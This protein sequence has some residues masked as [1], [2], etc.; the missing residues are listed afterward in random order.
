MDT[1]R[2]VNTTG[3]RIEPFYFGAA[4]TPLFGLLHTPAAASGR[5][6]CVVI[7][8]PAGHEY[9]QSHR[10]LRVLAER[11]S[12]TGFPALRF[13][14]Y[15]C[16]DSSGDRDEGTVDRWRED[17]AAAAGE[18]QRRTARRRL[19]LI[20]LGLGASLACLSAAEL[21]N[22]D[23]LILWDPVL[24]GTAYLDALSRMHREMMRTAHVLPG[25]AAGG[26]QHQEALGFPISE[27]LASG[28]RRLDLAGI[29]RARARQ[30]LIIETDPEPRARVLADRLEDFGSVVSRQAIP[31]E[32]WRWVESFGKI[33]VPVPVIA[34]IV[35]WAGDRCP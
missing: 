11:L 25:E 3:E 10:A 1:N 26:L 24:D 14:Y 18:A 2:P 15:G 19:C 17:T 4:G 7:C 28:L 22:V 8:P 29:A 23:T 12:A 33:P 27:S 30:A 34:S 16:G 13:D 21:G 6:C 32:P 20:G 5:E 9:V 35:R 31:A